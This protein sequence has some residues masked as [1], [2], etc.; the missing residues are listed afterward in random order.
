[1]TIFNTDNDKN[2][3][4]QIIRLISF[5]RALRRYST[6]II[7][8]LLTSIFT[9][10]Y[11]A[12]LLKRHTNEFNSNNYLFESEIELPLLLF[13][14]IFICM[15]ILL[16][17]RFSMVRNKGMVI[18]EEITDEIDWSRKR[19]EFIHRPPLEIRIQIKEF[20]KSTD[21]PFTTGPN[22]QAFYLALYFIELI[23]TI[24]IRFFS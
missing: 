11:Y 10:G 24:L 19:K 23:S 14:F 3:D 5:T 12:I 6:L 22:G 17:L 20:L 13:I 21:L 16:L 4:S 7:G 1:M 9:L 8:I 15:G 18:Y 2:I